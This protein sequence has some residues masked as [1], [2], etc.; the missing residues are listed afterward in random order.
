MK[1]PRCPDGDT[2]VSAFLEKWGALA[3]CLRDEFRLY[4]GES[5]V[6][7]GTDASN[8]SYA[9]DDDQRQHDSIL[10]CCGA[11]FGHEEMLHLLGK[12]LHRILQ[13]KSMSATRTVAGT[14]DIPGTCG[15]CDR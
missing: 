4:C 13:F 2:E 9:N 1:K 11:I 15:R 14:Q 5:R 8:S 6:R 10:N 3:A 12:A 7:T